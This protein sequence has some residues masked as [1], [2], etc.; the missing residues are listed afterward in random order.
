MVTRN[1]LSV[2]TW[3]DG[4]KLNISLYKVT[5]G[6]WQMMELLARAPQKHLGFNFQKTTRM[7]DQKY[8]CVP[9]FGSIE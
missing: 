1:K 5:F 4:K 7:Y 2:R 3:T 6:T 9:S 8:E